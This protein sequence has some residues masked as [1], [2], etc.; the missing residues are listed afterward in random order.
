MKFEVVKICRTALERQVSETVNIKMRSREG[1]RIL[2]SKIEYNRC[3]IPSLTVLGQGG[4]SASPTKVKGT[5]PAS[6]PT[7]VKPHIMQASEAVKLCEV[8]EGVDPVTTPNPVKVTVPAS[9]TTVK[10]AS[11]ASAPNPVEVTVEGTVPATDKPH[12]IQA[13]KAVKL[14]E[15]GEVEE[16]VPATVKPH[17]IPAIKAVKLCE[18]DE[19]E[20]TVPATVK[21]HII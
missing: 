2:N 8:A 20:G 15:V 9:V 21:P 3:F 14:F 12:I 19:V 11:P 6:V 7:T 5:V 1:S 4:V 17:I 18:V 13:I 10:G 16:T